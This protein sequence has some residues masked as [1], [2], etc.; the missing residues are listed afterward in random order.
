MK[1]QFIV[2]NHL[3]FLILF[4]IG[5]VTLACGI[6][7]VTAPLPPTPPLASSKTP[8][9]HAGVD[10]LTQTPKV[11]ASPAAQ[12]ECAV[13]FEKREMRKPYNS[14]KSGE[15]RFTLSAD[16]FSSYLELMGIDTLCIPAVFGTPFLNVDWDSAAATAAQGRMVS[17]GF[18]GLYPGFGWSDGYLLYSTYDFE[19]GSEY[20]TFAKFSDFQA[21]QDGSMPHM[22]EVDGVKGFSRIHKGLSYNAV[23]LFKTIIFPFETYYIALVY[24]VG[25]YEDDLDGI[26]A[27]LQA[28]EYPTQFASAV[29]FDQ[30]ATTI[31]FK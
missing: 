21:V 4:L 19:T 9:S 2:I 14:Q 11:V 8:L 28:G 20:D 16:E 7:Q 31:Q 24:W 3:S 15:P 5:L 13:S 10:T 18:E 25:D 6:M 17:I 29:R 22:L 23:P 12:L 26:S 27:R 30:M 1:T